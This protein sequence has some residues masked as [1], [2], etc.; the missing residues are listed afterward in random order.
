MNF[1]QNCN[2]VNLTEV[3]R[4]RAGTVRTILLDF[5]TGKVNKVV[6]HPQGKTL[7]SNREIKDNRFYTKGD[8]I[9][10]GRDKFRK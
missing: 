4:A 5:K 9:S 2:N 3:N 6:K 1:P 8:Q 10:V 7:A